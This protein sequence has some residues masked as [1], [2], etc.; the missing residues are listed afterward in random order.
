[1]IVVRCARLF[2]GERFRTS[3]TV[4][5]DDGVIVGVETEHLEL[6][7]RWRVIDGGEDATV[8][9]G[10]IDTHTHLVADSKLGALD[11][12]PGMT[13]DQLD[14]VITNP[15]RTS[16]SAQPCRRSRRPR[17]CGD[18]LLTSVPRSSPRPRPE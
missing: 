4:L 1:M 2:D 3:P 15:A 12:V 6:D 17:S 11:R 16:S 8:L 18:S 13:D 9:P 14:D 10:L 7:E 5:G